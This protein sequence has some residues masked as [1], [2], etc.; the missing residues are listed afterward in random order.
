MSVQIC[1]KFHVRIV[2]T[3]ILHT[4]HGCNVAVHEFELSLR[5]LFWR[6][7]LQFLDLKGS[8]NFFSQNTLKDKN[9]GRYRDLWLRSIG[10]Q[11]S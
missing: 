8:K 11:L 2:N 1:V 5:V 3:A 7:V 9:S 4:T 6:I 10:L